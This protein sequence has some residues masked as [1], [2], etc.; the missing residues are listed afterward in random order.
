MPH[1]AEPSLK[2]HSGTLAQYTRISASHVVRRPMNI[3]PTQAAGIPIAAL[4]AYQALFNVA[5]LKPEQ[6]VFINGGSTSVGAFAIQ[7]AKAIGC[8]VTVSASGRNEAFV[9]SLGAD[10]V[11]VSFLSSITCHM[12]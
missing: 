11:N 4:T 12:R 1:L 7:F 8:N 3:T 9:R 2:A 6:H 10:G 5:H